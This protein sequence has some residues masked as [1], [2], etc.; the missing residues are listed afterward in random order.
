MSKI[1]KNVTGSDILIPDTGVFIQANSSYTID[2]QTYLLW[3]GSV[4]VVPLIN[5]GSIVIN[6]S[7]LDLT[8]AEGIRYLEYADRLD[9]QINGTTITKTVKTL[10]LTGNATLVDNT[11]GKATINVNQ[12]SSIPCLREVTPVQYPF[13]LL[14]ISSDLLFEADPINDTI[15]FFK[16]VTI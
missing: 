14:N 15:L 6:N 10:N 5:A 13:G 8:P 7:T 16:E 12:A 1:V 3:A 4:D 2:L 9:V 11:N